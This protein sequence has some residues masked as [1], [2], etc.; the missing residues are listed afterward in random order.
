[1][2]DE[3]IRDNDS[4]L[5]IRFVRQYRPEDGLWTNRVIAEYG[6][7]YC[8]D[9]ACPLCGGALASLLVSES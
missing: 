5:S 8:D 9:P 7:H 6:L 4:G 2:A 3:V 1:M